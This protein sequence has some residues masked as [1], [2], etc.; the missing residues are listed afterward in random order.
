[1]KCYSC[2]GR[3]VYGKLGI[4]RKCKKARDVWRK[5]N[6]TRLQAVG[7]CICKK[8]LEPGY[9]TCMWC[10]DKNRDRCQARTEA[11]RVASKCTNCKQPSEP[12][13]ARCRKHLDEAAE[14]MREH[15]KFWSRDRSRMGT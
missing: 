11:A 10:R 15:R 9:L 3:Y 7:L 12:G 1:M 5:A 2:R 6:Q 8:K 14:R 4:C 13:R